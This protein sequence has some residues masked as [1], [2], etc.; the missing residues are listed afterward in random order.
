[1]NPFFARER[2]RAQ[3]ILNA[4]VALRHA[5]SLG[6]PVGGRTDDSWLANCT[7][8]VRLPT[9]PC[10]LQSSVAG[11]LCPS[12]SDHF[13]RLHMECTGTNAASLTPCWLKGVAAA[14]FL[15]TRSQSRNAQQTQF[16]STTIFRCRRERDRA[17][18]PR[19]EIPCRRRSRC[20]P[21]QKSPTI[22]CT[23]DVCDRDAWHG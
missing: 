5:Q 23:R 15:A 11:P 9:I 17:W 3:A 14:E 6:D 8:S 12:N 22:V 4:V 10:R 2:G 19:R 16:H 7:D 20:S 18:K 21:P 1:V 13:A